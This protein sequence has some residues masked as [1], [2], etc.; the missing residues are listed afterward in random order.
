M[1]IPKQHIDNLRRSVQGHE[2]RI[3]ELDAAVRS[4]KA[5]IAVHKVLIDIALNDRLIGAVDSV[6]D[7][8]NSRKTTFAEDLAAY[9]EQNSISLPSGL[10]IDSVDETS[11]PDAF[12]AEVRCEGW[13]VQIAWDRQEGF[14][15]RPNSVGMR[16]GSGGVVHRTDQGATRY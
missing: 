12:T 11:F 14:R 7:G 4:A 16:M 9:C 1:A 10:T 13:E 2:R 5:E 6:I 3:E 15:A 8:R